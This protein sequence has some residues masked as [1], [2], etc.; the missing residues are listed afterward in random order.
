MASKAPSDIQ[1]ELK[2]SAQGLT[3]SA[4]SVEYVFD[5]DPMPQ[6]AD[7]GQHT[8]IV[9]MSDRGDE[10]VG[11]RSL[12][13]SLMVS[14]FNWEPQ[15]DSALL[16]VECISL[17]NTEVVPRSQPQTP[18]QTFAAIQRDSHIL[19]K[20]VALLKQALNNLDHT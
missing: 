20:R 7:D 1:F 5:D 8:I 17:D 14:G 11:V 13:S 4:T 6:G 9:D 19:S 2:D 12:S 15:T 18:Q 10:P 3:Y 16:A